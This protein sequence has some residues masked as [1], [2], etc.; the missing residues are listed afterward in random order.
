MTRPSGASYLTNAPQ[1]ASKP[2]VAAAAVEQRKHAIYDAECKL[3]GWKFVPFVL[4]SYGGVGAEARQLLETMAAAAP[5]YGEYR[6]PQQFLTHAHN[7]LSVALQTGNADLSRKGATR[8][9]VRT[10]KEGGMLHV[11][12]GDEVLVADT[13]QPGVADLEVERRVQMRPFAAGAT[14]ANNTSL[15]PWRGMQRAA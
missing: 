2:L 10:R 9:R 14:V 3:Q 15:V 1:V 8:H 5:E 13:A 12:V 7:A 6:S 11:E 4:E